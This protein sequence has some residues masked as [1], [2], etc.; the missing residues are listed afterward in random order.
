MILNLFLLLVAAILFN[1]LEITFLHK[2]YQ[3][4]LYKTYKFQPQML[5]LVKNLNYRHFIIILSKDYER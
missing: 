3:R 2:Y 5:N 1:Y 4:F